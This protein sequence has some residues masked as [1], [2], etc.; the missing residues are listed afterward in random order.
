MA[1]TSVILLYNRSNPY[2]LKKD[3]VLIE[4]ALRKFGVYGIQ[5]C[6]PL[7]PPQK[8]DCIIHLE[9]PH[10]VWQSWGRTNMLVVNPEWYVPAAYDAYLQYFDWV[11]FKNNEARKRFVAACPFVTDGQ[12]LTIPWSSGGFWSV[13]GVATNEQNDSRMGFACFLGASKNR[14]DFLKTLLPFW[15][16]SY[17]QLNIFSAI[18]LS[19][20]PKEQENIKVRVEDLTEAQRYRLAT[21]FPGH[22]VCSASEGYSYTGGEAEAV[23]AYTIH[24]TIEAFL[25]SYKNEVGVAWFPVTAAES[26]TKYAYAQFAKPISAEETQA[27]LDQA[28]RDFLDTDMTTLR[29]KRKDAAMEKHKVFEKGWAD[30]FRTM[31]ATLKTKTG[32]PASSGLGMR[33]PVLKVEECPPIS[34]VTL[35][36]NRK[37]F[38]DLA[39]HNIM[40]SDYPK[41]K[42]EWILVDDSDDPEEQG[43]EKIMAVAAA[44]TPLKMVYV[45]LENRTPISEKRNI[46]VSKATNSIVLM[47]DDDDHYPE[48]SFR[49]RVA[50]LTL[51]PWKPQV[52]ACTT[53][54]CYD[55]VKAISAVNVPPFD[56]PLSERISEATLT[57]Y[58]SFWEARGFSR[59]VQ[60]GEGETFIRGRE[61]AVLEL[62]PQQI[63]VAFSHGK[64]TSSR[65]VP[66]GD[67]V[68]P[69]CFWNFPQEYLVFIH[70]MAGIKVQVQEQ[71]EA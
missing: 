58:K 1:S 14:H 71:T 20:S 52:T 4:A 54:A 31:P 30:V 21:F 26:D 69:G 24:T 27:A 36:Y 51:H 2:G 53:I 44:S 37:R 5:H 43:G 65:R 56:L 35:I 47:M 10:H 59:D 8:A 15:R 46:G 60:V 25:S 38:F 29:P 62:P 28:I 11:I 49:R 6:D 68:K 55:L 7:E 9:Q 63:I 40:M 66:G 48:T 3:A 57:F 19:V 64:N 17:P 23:G 33:P 61:T 67:D 50:W 34:I 22:V 39:C 45:R 42:I 13:E 12:T 41:D 32:G 16:E 70:K 18:D